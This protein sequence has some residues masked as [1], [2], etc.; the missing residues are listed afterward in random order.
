MSILR[1]LYVFVPIFIFAT[2][3]I[4]SPIFASNNQETA[5]S[6]IANAEEAII[7]TYEAV[8]E[9]EQAGGNVT[10]LFAQLNEAGE[11]LA[12]ARMSYRNGDFDNATHLADLSN[13]IGEEVKN[14]AI[15]LKDLAWNE[16]VQRTLFAMLGSISGV[17]S[18][19]LGSLWV[20]RFLKR[21]YQ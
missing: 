15:E 8:L 3:V 4:V 9:A 18:V 17:I 14:S 1:F 20:W 5:S 10:G 6:A 19:I 2:L 12:A 7:L 13:N 11:F 16:G 21:R